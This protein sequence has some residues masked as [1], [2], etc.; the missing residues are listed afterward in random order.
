[1]L[2]IKYALLVVTVKVVRFEAT[3]GRREALEERGAYIETRPSILLCSMTL[4]N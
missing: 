4:N 1:M 3:V 2:D